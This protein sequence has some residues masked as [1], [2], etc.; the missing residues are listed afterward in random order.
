MIGPQKVFQN[1]PS[2]ICRGDFPAG[3]VVENLPSNTGDVCSIPDRGTKIPHAV[4]QIS[5]NT[6]TR[7]VHVLL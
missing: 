2:K 5:L 3:P 7:E 6:A 4:G 1:F